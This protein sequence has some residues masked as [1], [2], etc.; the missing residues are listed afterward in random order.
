MGAFSVRLYFYSFGCG[1]AVPVPRLD[2]TA[3]GKTTLL[4]CRRHQRGRG[5]KNHPAYHEGR[6]HGFVDTVVLLQPV[7]LC[8]LDVLQ[9][10]RV[11]IPNGLCVYDDGW[12]FGGDAVHAVSVHFVGNAPCLAPW[13]F[14]QPFVSHNDGVCW[15]A[16]FNQET[17]RAAGEGRNLVWGVYL[18]GVHRGIFHQ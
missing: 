15:A 1:R 6:R 9:Q 4:G 5:G 17:V 10:G 11:A 14:A 7:H 3:G 12:N 18:A 16:D 2:E 8:D 13:Q